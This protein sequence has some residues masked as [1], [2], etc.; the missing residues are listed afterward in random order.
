[1]IRIIRHI[2]LN[3]E[4]GLL[5][6]VKDDDVPQRSFLRLFT[7]LVR[8]VISVIHF[9]SVTKKEILNHSSPSSYSVTSIC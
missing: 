3:H 5:L 4:L 7:T 9:Y 2:K 8:A 6:E 1:M